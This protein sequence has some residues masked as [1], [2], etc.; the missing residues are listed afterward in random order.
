MYLMGLLCMQFYPDCP[1]ADRAIFLGQGSEK[2]GIHRLN[3]H[4]FQLLGAGF[5]VTFYL[6]HAIGKVT[7]FYLSG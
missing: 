7:G 6:F 5:A 1:A 2:R 3:F 4:E